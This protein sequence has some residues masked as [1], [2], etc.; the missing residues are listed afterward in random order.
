MGRLSDDGRISDEEFLA[1]KKK[2]KLVALAKSIIA[3]FIFISIGFLVYEGDNHTIKKVYQYFLSNIEEST[4]GTIVESKRKLVIGRVIS[5]RIYF[6]KYKYSVDSTE[7]LGDLINYNLPSEDVD[8]ILQNYPVGKK[9]TVYYDASNP[10]YSI[11]E[12]TFLSKDYW[13]MFL[14]FPLVTP[15]IIYGF[16]FGLFYD[17]I[18]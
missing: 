17:W 14:F 5:K 13:F 3:Y 16:Y 15:L 2:K 4:I 8:L 12:K 1:Y 11:L 18:D 10:N 9:V 7:F 6:I